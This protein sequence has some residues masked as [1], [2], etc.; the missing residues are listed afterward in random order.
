MNG[1]SIWTRLTL[2]PVVALAGANI[3]LVLGFWRSVGGGNPIV[4][5]VIG[6]CLVL[7]EMTG[8]VVA[9]DA[10]ADGR[11]PQARAWHVL[12]VLVLF[13]N[14]FADYGAVVTR[15]ANDAQE[16]AHNRA[17]YDA[18]VA[19]K[20]EAERDITR[21]TRV[22]DDNDDNK[23]LAALR[24]ERTAAL[25][26]RDAY[27]GQHRE[28]PR[29]I[30][31]AVLRAETVLASAEDLFIAQQKRDAASATLVQ[32]GSRPEAEH[33]Q[34]EAVAAL[35]RSLGFSVSA[36][37]VRVWLAVPIAVILKLVLMFG[38]WVLP[39]G[40]RRFRRQREEDVVETPRIEVVPAPRSDS[41][42][43]PRSTDFDSALEDFERGHV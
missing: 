2:I 5:Q 8:L 4:Y 39:T 23:P 20:A 10:V 36:G 13:V 42:P 43:A 30:A 27:L 37:T 15:T 7:I 1:A 22:L 31:T 26:R 34:F 16:R 21:L 14:L 33:P 40:A 18:A 17:L 29:R 41:L 38:F 12:F 3:A 28:V 24:A 19:S 25:A 32:Y 6:V 9:A 35:L 11:R